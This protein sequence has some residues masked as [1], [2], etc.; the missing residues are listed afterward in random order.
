MDGESTALIRPAGTFS[1]GEKGFSTIASSENIQGAV[2][3]PQM[4]P[5]P[6]LWASPLKAHRTTQVHL[7]QILPKLSIAIGS[8]FAV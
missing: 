5:S 8:A 4:A 1:R 3:K 7:R 2:A 6:A